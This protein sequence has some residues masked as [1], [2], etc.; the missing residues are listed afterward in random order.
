[1]LTAKQYETIG[2]LTIL[3]NEID[4]AVKMYLPL[5]ARYSRYTLPLSYGEQSRFRMRAD[6]FR[7]ALNSAAEA[8]LLAAAYADTVLKFLNTA[9]KVATKRNEYVHAVVFIDWQTNT[10]MLQMRSGI[11]VPDAEQIC[12]LAKEAAFVA[13]ML[14]ESCESLLKY[15]LGFEQS[16]F[17][18]EQTASCDEDDESDSHYYE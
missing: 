13:W 15:Y 18:S 10:R 3:F 1:M 17:D 11:V 16:A 2:R 9:D 5:I 8:D 4:E 7:K 14:A 6:I 12:D